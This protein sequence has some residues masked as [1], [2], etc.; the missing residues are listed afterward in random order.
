MARFT[1]R[2]WNAT[3]VPA[4]RGSK[5]CCEP[6]S[7]G[8]IGGF[9]WWQ[10]GLSSLQFSSRFTCKNRKGVLVKALSEIEQL[11]LCVVSG[12]VIHA[13]RHFF[14]RYDCDCSGKMQ[15]CRW[16]SA[17]VLPPGEERGRKLSLDSRSESL[18]KR[19][20][21]RGSNIVVIK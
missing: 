9:G 13:F 15:L 16:K 17:S 10:R 20:R 1:A 11:R 7:G 8:V 21:E 5:R 3:D 18:L 4:P 14:S 2:S 12:S 19:E 6:L